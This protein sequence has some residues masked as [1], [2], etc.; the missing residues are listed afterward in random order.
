MSAATTLAAPSTAPSAAI[1]PYLDRFEAFRAGRAGLE[2]SFV[3][4]QREAGIARFAE[5]GFPTTTNE[6]WRFTNLTAIAREPF[7]LPK[8]GPVDRQAV[9]AQGFEVGHRIVF[10]DGRFAP[11]LSDLAALPPGVV[12]D[13]LAA[14]LAREPHRLEPHLGRHAKIG[15]HPFVALNSAFFAD[16][17]FV[18]IPRGVVVEAP[19]QLL[20]VATRAAGA[21]ALLALRNVIVARES[22]QSILVETYAGAGGSGYL[23]CIVTEVVL[24]ANAHVDHSKIQKDA[25][26]AFHLATSQFYQARSS[27]LFS[28]SISTGGG[29]V[30]NDVNAVLDGEGAEC[31]LNGLYVLRGTQFLDNHMRVDHAKA[32]CQSFELFKGVLDERSRAVFNGRI[33][34]AKGA[35]KTDAKQSSRN[36]LLSREA[37][38]N[39]NPQLEIF[40]D[41]VKCTHG[42]T[43]GQLDEDAIFYLRSRGI[44]EEAARSLLTYAFASDIVE[45]IR[46]EPVRHELTEFLFS[47]LPKGDVVRQA[48]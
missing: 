34:V 10:V 4:A 35:Q 17:V 20:Y 26:D 25:V 24:E 7:E 36:L 15:D 31:T 5:I 8:T 33:F 44:G 42:S 6:E 9:L 12:V 40:A 39:A 11:E 16:G 19:I 28:H 32:H 2:P 22:S 46:V 14:M 18:E 48:V 23:N 41:D 37:L 3:T 1:V 29:F 27:N 21:R 30:R 47:R 43:V 45:R 13:S 38:V